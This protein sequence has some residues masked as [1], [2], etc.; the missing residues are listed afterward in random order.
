MRRSSID[1]AL[2]L[3]PTEG[4]FS[5][6]IPGLQVLRLDRGGEAMPTVYQPT[7]CLILQ[8]AKQVMVGDEIVRYQ[9]GE[10]L[11]AS[12]PIP[13]TG[14]VEAA[15]PA[16]PY[17]GVVL[18]LERSVVVDMVSRLERPVSAAPA[19]GLALAGS[20]PAVA[21]GFERLLDCLDR[22]DDARVLAP[23]LSRE[24]IY[25]LLQGSAGPT[26]MAMG[27]VDGTMS[28]IARAIDLIRHGLDQTWSVD[29]LAREAGMSPS[30]FHRHFR[31]ITALTPV[32]YRK[33]LQLAE[34]RRLLITEGLSAAE[35]AFRV[36][37]ESPSQFS[38]EY[39]RRFGLPPKRDL[40]R[41]SEGS[42][43][44][45]RAGEEVLP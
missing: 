10:V 18:E 27:R 32:Q 34:A 25:R 17:L 42:A 4:S 31:R 39:G 6:P 29:A 11:C 20:D 28:R 22:E 8:G 44:T 30:S 45:R 1:R 24:I 35:A 23:I 5:T 2:R 26:L 21:D 33:E 3:A 15:S 9:A 40:L 36:G 14:M 16:C 37:Y 7:A 43:G 19:R 38:R 41:R 13:V 12:L